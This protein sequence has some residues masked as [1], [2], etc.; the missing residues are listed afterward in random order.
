MKN[1]QESRG[2]F[3]KVFRIAQ[4]LIGEYLTHIGL[5]T[6]NRN[7]VGLNQLVHSAN[8]WLAIKFC[9]KMSLELL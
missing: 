2:G 3:E 1:E 7:T 6:A 8:F 4:R 9:S 5:K